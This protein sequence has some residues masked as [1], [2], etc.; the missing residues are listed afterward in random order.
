MRLGAQPFLWKWLLFA[1]EWKMISVSKAEHLPSFWN[2]GQGELENGLFLVSSWFTTSRNKPP[3]AQIGMFWE[4]E[5]DW[6]FEQWVS[7]CIYA[8]ML[9]LLLRFLTELGP[10]D[11]GPSI[12]FI[13]R[14][15]TFWHIN[16]TFSLVGKEPLPIVWTCKR[17]HF[18]LPHVLIS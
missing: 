10:W 18:Y 9:V 5:V 7:W 13:I 14:S 16:Q 3:S 12:Y 17:F 6:T 15:L 11:F 1:L 8:S 2:R 4:E